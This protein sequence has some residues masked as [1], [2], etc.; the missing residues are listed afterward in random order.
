MIKKKGVPFHIELNSH[1]KYFGATGFVTK[2]ANLL[3]GAVSTLPNDA[4]EIIEEI[5]SPATA[6]VDQAAAA[7]SRQIVV[8]SGST[9]Q[10]GMV[11][12]DENNNMYYISK[13]EGNTIYT[14]FPLKEDIA[15]G[16]T[17]TQVGNTGIY[18]VEVTINEVGSF[19]VYISNPSIDLRTKG[20]Q[21]TIKEIMLEDVAQSIEDN[22]STVNQ[23]LDSI[24][25]SLENADSENFTVYG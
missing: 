24:Q 2:V 9:L 11:F 16:S 20:I 21:Y 8:Q 10:D 17:L 7:G 23:K 4:E 13:I 3:T 5:D 25:A 15:Y 12:K 22:F 1:Q 19:G 6:T 18:M 14:K